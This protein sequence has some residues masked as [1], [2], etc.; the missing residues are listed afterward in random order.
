[1][2]AGRA[3]SCNLGM[4]RP[5]HRALRR[6]RVSLPQQVYHLTASTLNRD[7]W[8]KDFGA[9]CAAARCF[10]DAR[11]LDDAQM[12]AWV[13]MPDQV[14]WLL[15]LGEQRSLDDTVTRLKS[16]SA[17]NAKRTLGRNGPLWTHAYHD[18]ALRR[19]EELAAVARYIVANPVRA[20]LVRRVGDWPFWNAVWL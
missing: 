18:R 19:E 3:R 6:G 9:A 7:P 8:F 12:L 4:N 5:G 20:G 1:M 17:R 10:A 2:V 14:H 16:A 13:L 11:L 15:Q